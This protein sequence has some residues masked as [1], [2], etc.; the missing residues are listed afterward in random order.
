MSGSLKEREK[1]HTNKAGCNKRTGGRKQGR[2]ESVLRCE[3]ALRCHR[4]L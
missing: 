2:G 3:A 1:R 4:D